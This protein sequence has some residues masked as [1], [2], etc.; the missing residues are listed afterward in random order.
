MK[1]ILV[2]SIWG[3]IGGFLFSFQPVFGEEGIV[4]WD[5]PPEIVGGME[6]LQ[7]NIVYPKEAAKEG[8]QGMVLVTVEIQVDG[9]VGK[10]GILEGVRADLDQAAQDAICK[11]QWKPAEKD[12]EPISCTVTIPVQ[13]KLESKK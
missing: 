3:V 4:E 12:G 11:T 1:T 10:V 9:A 8:A 13:F 2:A 5:K 6:A 7:K